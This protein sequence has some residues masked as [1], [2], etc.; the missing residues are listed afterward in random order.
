MFSK[1]DDTVRFVYHL[2]CGR[3]YETKGKLSEVEDITLEP[4]KSQYGIVGYNILFKF[5]DGT[6]TMGLY[7]DMSDDVLKNINELTQFVL[8]KDSSEGLGSNCGGGCG[9]CYC[10][11][12]P[13][14]K[15]IIIL[16]SVA[17]VAYVG[18]SFGLALMMKSK[19]DDMDDDM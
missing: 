5:K 9:S 14:Y 3:S 4:I 2:G 10:Q 18:A 11:C 1:T 12:W 6:P 19:L 8:G 15:T 17:V 7:Q 13:N 16:F